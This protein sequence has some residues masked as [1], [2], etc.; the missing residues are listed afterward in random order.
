M[1]GVFYFDGTVDVD[2]TFQWNPLAFA[3]SGPSNEMER[4]LDSIRGL[5]G[6]TRLGIFRICG[7]RVGLF[8]HLEDAIVQRN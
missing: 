2:V 7:R 3:E 6:F 5:R 1:F 8:H 4:P